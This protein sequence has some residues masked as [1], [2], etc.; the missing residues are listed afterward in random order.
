MVARA[1]GK[2]EDERERDSVSSG[3]E[4]ITGNHQGWEMHKVRNQMMDE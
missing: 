2:S 1:P 4:N 3:R